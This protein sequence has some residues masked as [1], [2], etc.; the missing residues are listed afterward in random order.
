MACFLVPQSSDI[1]D[2]PFP[3]FIPLAGL[4]YS[5]KNVFFG[6]GVSDVGCPGIREPVPMASEF[7]CKRLF[8]IGAKTVMEL[9]MDV[10]GSL[11]VEVGG[12]DA[13]AEF[14]EQLFGR[15]FVDVFEFLDPFFY[16]F[17][18]AAALKALKGGEKL[19]HRLMV[20]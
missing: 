4:N 10:D 19:A 3:S 12:E 9:S 14:L 7:F 11:C 20:F 5:G 1:V 2:E 13:E 15:A 6:D 16:F 8:G 17:F 18:D